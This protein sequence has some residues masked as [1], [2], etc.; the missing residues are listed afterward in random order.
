ME[1]HNNQSI[2]EAQRRRVSPRQTDKQ[3]PEQA[4]EESSECF[5][6]EAA[7]IEGGKAREPAFE[8][9]EEDIFSLLENY[10]DRLVG[11]VSSDSI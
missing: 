9:R 8:E 2:A 5:E 7:G 1:K 10:L 4:E 3:K 11:P 6:P